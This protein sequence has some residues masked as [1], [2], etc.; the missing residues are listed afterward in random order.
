MGDTFLG[1]IRQMKQFLHSPTWWEHVES[2]LERKARTKDFH[3]SHPAC[4]IQLDSTKD[5]RF[6]LEDVHYYKPPRGRK[7]PSED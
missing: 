3:C 5:L 7:R 6:H 4:D 2:H 1:P